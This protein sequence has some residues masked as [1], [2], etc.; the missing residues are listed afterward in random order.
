MGSRRPDSTQSNCR[1]HRLE[2][3]F[4]CLCHSLLPCLPS[5]VLYACK[6]QLAAGDMSLFGVTPLGAG[7]SGLERSNSDFLRALSQPLLI[8]TPLQVRSAPYWL[9]KHIKHRSSTTFLASACKTEPSLTY[10]NVQMMLETLFIR[11]R[12]QGAASLTMQEQVR[13]FSSTK[14]VSRASG[15]LVTWA[16]NTA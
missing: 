15:R 16:S 3:T 13:R 4:C 10:P 14:A 2:A 9:F 12:E 1:A 11:S 8:Q 5:N 7:A 6:V